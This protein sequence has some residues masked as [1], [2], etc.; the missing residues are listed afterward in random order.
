MRKKSQRKASPQEQPFFLVEQWAWFGIV[1]VV[2]VMGVVWVC[3]LE[4]REF[5]IMHESQ[6]VDSLIERLVAGQRELHEDIR[7]I[8]ERRSK[9]DTLI[10]STH[11]QTQRKRPKTTGQY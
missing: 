6:T 4:N 8:K 9:G 2:N 1:G 3:F 5:Q 11:T 10:S 7:R